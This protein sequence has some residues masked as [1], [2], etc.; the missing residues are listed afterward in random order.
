VAKLPFDVC[1]EFGTCL[2]KG[3]TEM[4]TDEK[5]LKKLFGALLTGLRKNCLGD[6]SA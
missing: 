2:V 6:R 3:N 5:S 4:S 1:Q